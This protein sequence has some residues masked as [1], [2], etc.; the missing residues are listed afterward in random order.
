MNLTKTKLAPGAKLALKNY[1][2]VAPGIRWLHLT[3]INNVAC[4]IELIT[5]K[6]VPLRIRPRV[7]KLRS[8]DYFYD[9]YTRRSE[10]VYTLTVGWRNNEGGDQVIESIACE[11]KPS[12]YNLRFPKLSEVISYEEIKDALEQN[13]I[14]V[15]PAPIIDVKLLTGKQ[16]LDQSAELVGPAQ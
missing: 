5:S 9:Q 2:H 16:D 12:N 15:T 8:G 4:V 14:E 6:N 1:I 7:L 13:G 3:E 10:N 11:K